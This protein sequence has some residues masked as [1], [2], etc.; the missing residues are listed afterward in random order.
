MGQ[1]ALFAQPRFGV[2]VI[3]SLTIIAAKGVITSIGSLAV[4]FEVLQTHLGNRVQV[5]VI[6]TRRALVSSRYSTVASDGGGLAGS[7]VEVV[8]RGA[9]CTQISVS[10]VGHA[11][12]CVGS[13]FTVLGD[14]LH[15][16]GV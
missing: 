14:W 3:P 10:V 5:E 6:G 2:E 15:E 12:I 9:R 8:A 11:I 13:G 4:F 7:P 16:V 1:V